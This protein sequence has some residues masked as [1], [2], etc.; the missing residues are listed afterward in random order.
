MNSSA[1]NEAIR[2]V[3]GRVARQ[4][5]VGRAAELQRVVAQSSDE[6][7]GR[8]LLLLMEPAAGVSELLRQA[9]DEIFHQR[10][11]VV[12]IY[13]ALTAQRSFAERA[14]RFEKHSSCDARTGPGATSL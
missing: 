13:F 7:A 1:P 10:S 2:R 8:G 9:Y 6:Y 4:E 5:F 3:L 14:R 11:H 12:P